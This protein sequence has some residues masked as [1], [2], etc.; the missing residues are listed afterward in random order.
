MPEFLRRKREIDPH[1]R[2]SSDWYHHQLAL[3][4]L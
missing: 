3:L 2:L 4:G 1:E